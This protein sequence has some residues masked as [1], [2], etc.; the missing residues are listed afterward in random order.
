[1]ETPKPKN[2]GDSTTKTMVV[3][4]NKQEDKLQKY[5]KV[6]DKICNYFCWIA[7]TYIIVRCIVTAIWSI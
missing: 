2:Q 3:V 1:M 6:F 7:I 5:E 4:S